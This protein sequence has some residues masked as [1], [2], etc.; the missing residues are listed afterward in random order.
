MYAIQNVGENKEF[1]DNNMCIYNR[2]V[3][4]KKKANQLQTWVIIIS[5]A[6]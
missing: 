4:S 5:D 2:L 6:E 1:T 3:K